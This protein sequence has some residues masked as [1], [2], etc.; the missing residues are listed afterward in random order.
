M[1]HNT[2]LWYDTKQQIGLR[3]QSLTW[4]EKLSVISL[5]KPGIIACE[6]ALEIDIIN[7][8]T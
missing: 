6:C 7:L 3:Y 8:L 1:V 4:T 5:T 2:M